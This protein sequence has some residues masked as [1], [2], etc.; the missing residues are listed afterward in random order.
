[1]A[2]LPQNVKTQKTKKRRFTGERVRRERKR[3]GVRK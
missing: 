3:Y 1:L 2:S